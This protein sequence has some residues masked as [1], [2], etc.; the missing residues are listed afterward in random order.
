[1]MKMTTAA[2]GDT[3]VPLTTGAPGCPTAFPVPLGGGGSGSG[4]VR[5]LDMAAATTEDLQL[6]AVGGQ[7]HVNACGGS[8]IAGP[9]AQ[10]AGS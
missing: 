10:H 8:V 7:Q 1:M 5:S 9:A 2:V 3:E 6:M 4:S